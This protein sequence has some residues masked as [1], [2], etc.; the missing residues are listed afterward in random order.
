[1]FELVQTDLMG[2]T[3]TLSDSRHH[4]VIVLVDYHSRFTWVKFLKEKSEALS[5]FM[6]FNKA[7]AN[8]F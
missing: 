2:P 3:K 1:M 4:Y 5:K 7:V 8:D 6:E